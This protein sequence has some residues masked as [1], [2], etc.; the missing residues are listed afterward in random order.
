MGF[1]FQAACQQKITSKDFG[2]T[3]MRAPAYPLITIDPYTYAWSTTDQQFDGTVTHWTGKTHGLIG[4]IRVD[5]QVYRF[6][7]KESVPWKI[8][9]PIA[10]YEAW[11]GKF[12][13]KSPLEGWNLQDFNDASWD[14]GKG[15]FGTR[16]AQAR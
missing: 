11:N 6:L 5:G 10:T 13:T 1:M 15:A 8:L 7:G 16:G 3:E 9:A 12:T 4:A 14:A 2:A